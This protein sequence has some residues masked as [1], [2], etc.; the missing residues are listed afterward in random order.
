MSNKIDIILLDD[1][2]MVKEEIN[3]DRHQNYIELISI[4]KDK[5]KNLPKNYIIFFQ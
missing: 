1:S 2:N 3:L 4:I 5:I